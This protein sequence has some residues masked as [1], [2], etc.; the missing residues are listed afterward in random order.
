MSKS[1]RREEWFFSNYSKNALPL[2]VSIIER[3]F[4]AIPL[5]FIS[6]MVLLMVSIDLMLQKIRAAH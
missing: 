4:A 6:S 5:Q 2:N 1:Y 3:T